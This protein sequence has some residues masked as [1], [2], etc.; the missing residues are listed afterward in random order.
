MIYHDIIISHINQYDMM[1]SEFTDLELANPKSAQ[2]FQ[3][4]NSN[5]NAIFTLNIKPLKRT[6]IYNYIKRLR[7]KVEFGPTKPTALPGV[8]NPAHIRIICAEK[9]WQ[10]LDLAEK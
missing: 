3:A 8:E 10:M 5:N 1:W 9:L 7:D 4:A 2:F 6:K